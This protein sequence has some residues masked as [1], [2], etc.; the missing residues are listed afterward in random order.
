MC[1]RLF[2][3]RFGVQAPVNV[4]YFTVTQSKANLKSQEL[5]P[6]GGRELKNSLSRA[7]TIFWAVAFSKTDYGIVDWH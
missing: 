7:T 2:I 3:K 6:Y 4:D 1:V 5:Q